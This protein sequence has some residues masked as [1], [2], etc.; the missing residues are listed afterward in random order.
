MSSLTPLDAAAMIATREERFAQGLAWLNGL[1]AGE[2]ATALEQCCEAA[3][4]VKAMEARRPFPTAWSLFAAA[5][6]EWNKCSRKELGKLLGERGPLTAA[7]RA[8]AGR[9]QDKL[10]RFRLEVLLAPERAPGVSQQ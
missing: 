5:R 9:E 3:R 8:E 10:I 7:E 1:S 6:E 2:A 4:W